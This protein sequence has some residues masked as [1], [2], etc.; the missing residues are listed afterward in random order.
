MLVVA[1]LFCT[2]KVDSAT[3]CRC[4]SHTVLADRNGYNSVLS[5]C[6]DVRRMGWTSIEIQQS[7]GGIKRPPKNV[8]NYKQDETS[9]ENEVVSLRF[10]P[11]RPETH[12]G[13]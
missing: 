7:V 3:D 8:Q 5:L 4:S 1:S 6:R 9:G 12:G 2:L 13:T 11:G 10:L